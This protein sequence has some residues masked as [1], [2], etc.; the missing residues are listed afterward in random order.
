M[1]KVVTEADAVSLGRLITRKVTVAVPKKQQI[2]SGNDSKND[3]GKS[4]KGKGKS[5]VRSNC[6]CGGR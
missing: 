3:K 4:K 5:K 1:D 2:S 6:E